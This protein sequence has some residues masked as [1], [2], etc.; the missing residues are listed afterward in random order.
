MKRKESHHISKNLLK[1]T[2]VA[3]ALFTVSSMSAA[4]TSSLFD[5]DTM[6]SGSQVRSEILNSPS[7][8]SMN[9]YNLTAS[10]SK[11]LDA[12]CGENKTKDANCG[13]NK[14]EAKKDMKKANVKKEGKMKDASCGE[15]AAK[16]D[17]TKT[18]SKAKEGKCGEGTCGK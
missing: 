1:G 17:S 18:E 15:K 4:T 9:N 8:S 16:A 11:T 2:L 14:K 5:Y 10:D 3:G 12:S 13:A 7:S 6:G